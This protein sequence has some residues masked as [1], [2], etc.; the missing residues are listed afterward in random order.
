MAVLIGST[1]IKQRVVFRFVN[2]GVRFLLLKSYCLMKLHFFLLSCQFS[3]FLR[4]YG[5]FE[6][7]EPLAIVPVE[8]SVVKW[9]SDF[10]EVSI[11]MV[12]VVAEEHAKY[13]SI[14]TNSP[15]KKKRILF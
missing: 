10:A 6:I 14:N 4:R 11:R 2:R 15:F 12:A 13:C 9:T 1:S 7:D 5:L 3:S 8:V